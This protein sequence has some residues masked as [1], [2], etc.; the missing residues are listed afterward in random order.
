[1]LTVGNESWVTQ[2]GRLLGCGFRM[3]K[4]QE[5]AS[6]SWMKSGE[7]DFK[8][9]TF[10]AALEGLLFLLPLGLP[11]GLLGEGSQVGS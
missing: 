3:G 1:M 11:L 7:L 4:L 8:N 10:W 9:P 2:L 6:K 5:G